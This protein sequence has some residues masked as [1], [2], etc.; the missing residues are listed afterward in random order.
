MRPAEKSW[1]DGLYKCSDHY[2]QESHEC[3]TWLTPLSD[4]VSRV[5]NFGHWNSTEPYIL[6]WILNAQYL[7]VVEQDFE[8]L[9]SPN[10]TRA[11]LRET[12]PESL[13]GRKVEFIAADMLKGFSQ[14]NCFDLAYC[15][16][17]LYFMDE[18]IEI[19][20]QAIYEMARVVRPGGSII[21]VEPKMGVKYKNVPC[22][23]FGN[24][25]DFP[26]PENEP[27]DISHLFEEIGL[28][29]FQLANMPEYTY[30]YRKPL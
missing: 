27:V 25:M 3:L 12:L 6:L 20:K 7:L 22:I 2:S 30:C 11:C 23:L 29:S 26:F 1:F 28:V 4:R 14:A 10:Q 13:L 18:D 24:S 9:H 19:L 15:E 17:T 5:V 21:A 16:N 8:N